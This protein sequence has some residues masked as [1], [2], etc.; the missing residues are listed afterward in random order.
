MN[1]L[2]IST[3]N[4]QIQ[5][6]NL[7]EDEEVIKYSG[8]QHSTYLLDTEIMQFEQDRFLISGS[9]DYA[10]YIWDVATANCQ[11]KDMEVKNLNCLATNNNGVICASGFPDQNNIYIMKFE[12]NIY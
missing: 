11:R 8:H 7:Y 10:F 1:H 3:L 6:V 5:V 4:N 2:L 12:N 9:E